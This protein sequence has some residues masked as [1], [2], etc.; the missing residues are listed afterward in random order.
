MFVATIQ[1]VAYNSDFEHMTKNV[2]INILNTIF[3]LMLY[4]TV[5]NYYTTHLLFISKIN[6][7]QFDVIGYYDLPTPTVTKIIIILYLSYFIISTNR[8]Y[9]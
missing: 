6:K 2:S 7:Y 3:L 9:L 4:S 5:W 8:V 1:N